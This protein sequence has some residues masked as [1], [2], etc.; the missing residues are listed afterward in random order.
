MNFIEKITKLDYKLQKDEWQLE[1]K[2]KSLIW[3]VSILIP[4]VT[5]LML[6]RLMAGEVI[7]A[8]FDF[9]L[10]TLFSIVVYISKKHKR[11]YQ[12]ASTIF[13]SITTIII[14]LLIFMYGNEP[15]RAVW[16]FPM[17]AVI[18]YLKDKKEGFK[19]TIV[20]IFIQLARI[21]FNPN[22]NLS[23][24]LII[25]SSLIIM[26]SFLHFYEAMKEKEQ[27]YLIEL[28]KN[29]IFLKKKDLQLFQQ[30]RQAQMG[31][32]ISMIAHQWRQ[33]LAS[34]SSTTINIQM[35]I[36]LENFDLNTIDG[37][38]KQNRYFLNELKSIDGFVQNLTTTIDDFRNF[39][40][41]NKKTTRLKLEDVIEKSLKIINSSLASDNIKVI[42]QYNSK[43]EMQFYENEMMQV[44]LNIL[45]NTHDNFKEKKI[46]NPYIKITTENKTITICDNGGGISED[47][48]DKIFDPYFSTKDDK[49]GTGLGLYMS[50]T[51]IEEHHNGKLS[52]ENT[53][54]GVCFTVEL[55]IL[56]K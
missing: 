29:A 24:Y 7:N 5:M 56:E 21:Y 28:K 16:L 22:P 23:E 27:Q 9:V 25:I 38:E 44:I 50:K 49:N 15:L 13:I 11:Y 47:I 14:T 2:I 12:L 6:M 41:P 37:K 42:K 19:W 43:E 36:E 54:D 4:I 52:A 32:M 31:E 10:I 30:S 46:K 18:Y 35:S 3:V 34:I 20:F 48:M 1:Q 39:Y 26:A 17:L 51:I 40:K 45:K 53:D 33:P 55:G 8:I